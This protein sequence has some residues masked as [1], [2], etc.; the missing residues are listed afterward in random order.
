MDWIDQSE[1]FMSFGI[2]DFI[3]ADGSERVQGAM[4]TPQLTAL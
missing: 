1:G 3:D 2:L 4:F